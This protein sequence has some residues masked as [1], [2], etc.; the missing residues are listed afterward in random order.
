MT[1][2]TRT[3]QRIET[4]DELLAL[5]NGTILELDGGRVARLDGEVKSDH[6]GAYMTDRTGLLGIAENHL[7]ATVLKMGEFDDGVDPAAILDLTMEVEQGECTFRERLVDLLAIVWADPIGF[8]G[9]RPWGFSTW[10]QDF[11]RPMVDAGFLVETEPGGGM[12]LSRAERQEADRLIAAAIQS[13]AE[14][15]SQS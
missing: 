14:G 9:K 13:L 4:L 12:M 6:R 15:G 2:A 1:S 8:D 10:R 11:Y 7:P 3:G 5:P